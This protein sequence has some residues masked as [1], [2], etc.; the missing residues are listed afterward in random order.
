MNITKLSHTFDPEER[1]PIG[2][3]QFNKY[4]FT[5]GNHVRLNRLR[6]REKLKLS[7]VN[8]PSSI[9]FANAYRQ[10]TFGNYMIISAI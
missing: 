8:C 5:A 3:K 4:N 6:E 9:T 7:Q 2:V 10:G 1:K